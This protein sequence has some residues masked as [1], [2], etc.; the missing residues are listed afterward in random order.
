MTGAGGSA[1]GLRLAIFTDTYLPQVN[2]VSRTLAG[3]A[4]AVER[5]GGA[6][7]VETV[8]DPLARS[9]E[10]GVVRWPSLP[11]WA[12]PQLRIAA[13]PSPQG[14]TRTCGAV[15]AKRARRAWAWPNLPAAAARG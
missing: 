4:A 1:S 10:P 2:G 3:L 12:Y 8:E 15:S 11:F 14:S 7:R 13:P 6:V 5:R 9:A